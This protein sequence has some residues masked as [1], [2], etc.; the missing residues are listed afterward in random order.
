MRGG[1]VTR[2]PVCI[3]GVDHTPEAHPPHVVAAATQRNATIGEAGR[4]FGEVRDVLRQKLSGESFRTAIAPHEQ[5]YDAAHRDAYAAYV[6][7]IK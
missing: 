1:V 7:A 3:G 6:E 2:C 5:A 4:R